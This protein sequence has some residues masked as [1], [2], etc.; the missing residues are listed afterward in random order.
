MSRL[1]GTDPPPI[2]PI[3]CSLDTGTL[4]TQEQRW[5]E[6][7]RDAGI[8]RAPT[9]GGVTLTF[10]ADPAVERELRDL[11]ATENQCCAWARWELRT[12]DN[13][14]LQ[15]QARA[16]DGGAATLREMFPAAR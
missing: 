12:D 9:A 7:V 13:G 14:R 3:A 15:M 1:P 2:A 5:T 10:R 6:L 4:R 11:V 16:G 8:D